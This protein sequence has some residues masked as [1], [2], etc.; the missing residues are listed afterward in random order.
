VYLATRTVEHLDPAHSNDSE[1]GYRSGVFRDGDGSLTGTAGAYVTMN[2]AFLAAGACTYR[3]AW[4]A[5]VCDGRYV[6]LTLQNRDQPARQLAPVTLR[7][8]DVPDSGGAVHTMFGTPH[9]GPTVPNT[10]YRA[11]VPIGY[12]YHYGLAGV[13]PDQFT[14]DMYDVDPGDAL[15]V[16]VPYDGTDPYIYRDWWVDDRNV[17]PKFTSRSAFEASDLTGYY[18]EG[19]RLYL[20]LAQRDDR[21]WAHL[22][23]CRER[24]C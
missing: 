15:V 11:L 12:D 17:I 9:G 24:G 8:S 21:T 4:N 1:D 20:R 3:P 16:S 14:I 6:S 7:R 22:T 10:H 18:R 5:N 2:S 13:A 19:G 23:I